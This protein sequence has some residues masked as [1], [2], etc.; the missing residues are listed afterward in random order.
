MSIKPKSNTFSFTE[1]YYLDKFSEKRA[2][3]FKGLELNPNDLA[4][5]EQIQ[6]IDDLLKSGDNSEWVVI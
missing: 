4:I 6:F 1:K 5:K 3:L 2:E